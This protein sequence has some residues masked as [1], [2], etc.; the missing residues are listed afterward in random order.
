ML[1]VAAVAVP[2]IGYVIKGEM[3][4]IEDSR[5]MAATGLFF[6]ALAFWVIRGG[7]RPDRLGWFEGGVAVLA[8]ILCVVTAALAETAAAEIPLAAFMWSI[9]LVFA[10]DLRH[11]GSRRHAD[12]P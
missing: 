5:G 1:L 11:R 3:P 7:N 4:L 9:L 8:V 12:Q 10:V 6:G 2:Y